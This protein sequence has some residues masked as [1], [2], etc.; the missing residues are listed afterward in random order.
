V[1]E[2]QG[3]DVA[4]NLEI[5]VTATSGLASETPMADGALTTDMCSSLVLGK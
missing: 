2:C 1:V 3:L 5:D 4:W